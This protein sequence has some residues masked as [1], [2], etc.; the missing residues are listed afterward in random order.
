MHVAHYNA[1]YIYIK[2]YKYK[3]LIYVL[4]ILYSVL[5]CNNIN[6]YSRKWLC[7]FNID[8]NRKCTHIYNLYNFIK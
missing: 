7:Y 4:F 1:A 6:D 3:L 2:Q 8:R 5:L